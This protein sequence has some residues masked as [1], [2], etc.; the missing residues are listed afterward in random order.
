MRNV[1]PGLIALAGIVSTFVFGVPIAGAEQRY[2]ELIQQEFLKFDPQYLEK[3]KLYET[4]LTQ[5]AGEIA[6]AEAAGRDMHCSQQIYLEAKWLIHYSAYWDRI[7]DKLDRL[8]SSFDLKDQSFAASQSPVDGHWGVCHE[9]DFM[10][11]AATLEGLVKLDLKSQ[12]PIFKLKPIGGMETG[13]QLV[14]RL[15]SL[16]ISDIA[17]QGIDNRSE[18]GSLIT[19]IALAAFKPKIRA[20]VEAALAHMPTKSGANRLDIATEAFRFFLN[21]SQDAETGY[22]GAWYIVNGKVIKTPDLSFTYHIIGYTK[23]DV[24]RWPQILTTT[25]RIENDEYPYGW[26]HD[27]EHNNHNLYDVAKIYKYAWPNIPKEKRPALRNQI[28][29]MIDWS[30]ANT[31]T[32]DGQFKFDPSFSNSLAAEYYYGI[33]FLDVVGYWD[34]DRRFWT[35]EASE[36]GADKLCRQIKGALDTVGISGWEGIAARQKIERNCL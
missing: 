19:T 10:R 2:K 16:L 3:R 7:E 28:Q 27:G 24:A 31:I 25:A 36:P 32:E 29:S 5:L 21:A 20:M 1:L 30:L 11:L 34:D 15:N 33:S 6:R 14:D 26:K 4:D 23:G 8:R 17:H 13:K 12:K 22:W 35:E 18:L 9:E